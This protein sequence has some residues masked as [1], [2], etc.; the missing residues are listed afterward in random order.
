M[1]R[2]LILGAAGGMGRRLM[3]LAARWLPG[4]EILAG[5]HKKKP[6][7]GWATRQVDINDP[8]TLEQGFEGVALLINAV[9]PYTYDPSPILRACQ[10]SGC[11]YVDLAEDPDFISHVK[12]FASRNCTDDGPTVLTG[13]STI[14]GLVQVMVQP[15]RD[16][17][18][19]AN[20]DIYLS[21]GSRNPVA[22][23][24]AYSLLRPL[25]RAKIDGGRCFGRLKARKF[26][27]QNPLYFGRFP[28]PYDVSDMLLG[29]RTVPTR[30]WAGFDRKH[31]NVGLWLGSRFLSLLPDG[32]IRAISKMVVLVSPITRLVGTWNGSLTLDG[33]DHAGNR[34][35][36]IRIRAFKEGLNI[37]ALPAIWAAQRLL[38]GNIPGGS[39]LLEDLVTTDLA[40]QWLQ[41]ENYEIQFDGKSQLAS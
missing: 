40:T 17:K 29:G 7:T 36:E 4:V 38:A 6:D 25:G 32:C 16:R 11:D 13:C 5:I 28:S 31:L 41:S 9:G 21:M 27:D 33:M 39:C 35:A 30:F 20:I 3:N 34:V 22:P 2:I 19:I 37:P 12:A 15:W 1:K 10:K 26:E 8:A 23:G 24:L 18:D 14:P